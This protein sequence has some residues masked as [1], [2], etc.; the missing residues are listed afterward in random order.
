MSRSATS[1]TSKAVG[2]FVEKA[3]SAKTFG[4]QTLEYQEFH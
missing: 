4:G 2:N 1:M 3:Y